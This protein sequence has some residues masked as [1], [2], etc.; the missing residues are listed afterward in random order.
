[1]SNQITLILFLIYSIT[2]AQMRDHSRIL[3]FKEVYAK[4]ETQ[5]VVSI[6]DA[7]D[8]I[9]I[10]GNPEHIEQSIIV[11]TDKKWGLISFALDGSLL[12]KFPFGKLNNVDI[13]EDFNHNGETFPLIFGSNRT[14]N[15]IDIYRL[16]PNGHLER[17][18]QI[19]VPKLKDVYGITFYN[20]KRDKHLFISDKKGNIQQWMFGIN[21]NL[22]ALKL[23]R[24]IKVSSIV[25]GMVADEF[26]EK[27]YFAEENK[28]LWQVN[29]NIW[30]SQKLKLIIKTD[31][32][33][34][35][36]DFEGVTLLEQPNGAGMIFFS[37]QGS[38]AYGMMDRKSKKF[39]GG[40]KI[41]QS[42][43]I[44][45]VEDTDG[46]DVSSISSKLFPRGVFI[47]QDGDNQGK[48]QNYKY[49]DLGDILDKFSVFNESD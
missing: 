13:Y 31:K 30:E 8:D 16:F 48:N 28:G 9:C 4:V 7:A 5:P 33:K 12:N 3:P 38:N 6:D 14:D 29:V 39:I 21:Q 46:I 26:H 47:A 1:M 27:L 43:Q 35:K 37:I 42:D 32:D 36:A 11:G 20:G 18:N 34:L 44:D 22:P 10:W 25:E 17:L 23:L 40:F 24:T 49:V 45:S 15:T 2:N 41:V 19:K